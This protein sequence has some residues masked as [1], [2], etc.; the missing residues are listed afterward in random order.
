MQREARFADKVS[1]AKLIGT[2]AEYAELHALKILRGRFLTQIDVRTLRSVVVI[3]NE[4]ADELFA[5]R[6]PIGQ[7]LRT[8]KEYFIVVGVFD[9]KRTD[10]TK[11]D[12]TKQD[13]TKQDDTKQDTKL[14]VAKQNV[15][16]PITTMRARFGDNDLQRKAGSFQL[17]QFEL[18][19]IELLI[20][21]A[22]KTAESVKLVEKILEHQH[23]DQ[24]FKVTIPLDSNDRGDKR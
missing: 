4:M 3:S 10:D 13:D 5:N 1:D 7:R 19:T 21:D 6:D 23:E 8:D 14:R 16:I 17:D 18:S 2:V 24:T 9:S 15:Y 22:T 12:D 11:Q 20:D